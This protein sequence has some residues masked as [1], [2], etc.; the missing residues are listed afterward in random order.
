MLLLSILF[1]FQSHVESVPRPMP[2]VAVPTGIALPSDLYNM[3]IPT[4]NLYLPN[5]PQNLPPSPSSSPSPYVRETFPFV[6]MNFLYVI[7]GVFGFMAVLTGVLMVY[8]YFKGGNSL[9]KEWAK[10]QERLAMV[11][12]ELKKNKKRSKKKNKKT[13]K[14]TSVMKEQFQSE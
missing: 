14:S 10:E 6:M 2:Q 1:G 5:R 11:S 13:E 9:A 8:R 7:A 4:S 12:K 3:V